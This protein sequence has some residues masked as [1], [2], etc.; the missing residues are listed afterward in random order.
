MLKFQAVK[1]AGV[2][3][4][5]DMTAEAAF[6]KLCYVLALP[7]KSREEKLGLMMRNLRGELTESNTY[8]TSCCKTGKRLENAGRSIK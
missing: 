5:L 4:G 1:E 2:I 8:R 3:S 7:N 6:A